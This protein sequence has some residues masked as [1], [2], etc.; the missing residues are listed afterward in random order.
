MRFFLS[1]FT[2]TDRKQKVKRIHFKQYVFKYTNKILLATLNI[3]INTASGAL[4]VYYKISYF[5]SIP[6]AKF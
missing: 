6:T 3:V 5:K 4:L 1:N 2:V